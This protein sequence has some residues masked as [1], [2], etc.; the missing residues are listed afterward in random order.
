[1]DEFADYGELDMMAKYVVDVKEIQKKIVKIETDIE[2]INQV[3]NCSL[4][5]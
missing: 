3:E 4:Y 1:M 2:W 5:F